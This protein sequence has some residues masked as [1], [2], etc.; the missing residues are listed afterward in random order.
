MKISKTGFTN[1]IRC[2]RYGAL[3][4]IYRKKGQALVTFSEDMD[5]LMT[6]ENKSKTETLLSDMYDENDDDLIQKEDI[7]LN[8]MMPYY[9]EIEGLTAKAVKKLFEGEFTFNMLDTYKQKKFEMEKEGYYFYCFLDG[10]LEQENGFKIFETKST[11]SRKYMDMMHNKESMFA[12]SPEGIL[13]L[14]KDLGFSV[15]E[16]YEKK[17][18]KLLDRYSDVGRY[19]Y[20]LAFQRYVIE[21]SD[22]KPIGS[23]KYY[24]A[25]LNKDYVFDG[26]TDENSKPIYDES[27]IVFIDFTSITERYRPIIESD[28]NLVINNLNNMNAAPVDIGKHCQRK[29]RKQCQFFDICWKHVPTQNSILTYLGN[30]HGFTDSNGEKRDR[31]DLINEGIVEALQIPEDWLKRENNVIQRQVIESDEPYYNYRKIR[32]GILELRYP[33]Y[34]LDFESFPCPLPRYKGESPYM[35]SLFQYSIHIEHTPGVC[36]KELDN[37]AFLARNHDDPREALIEGMIDI[38][39]QDGGSV[40]VYNI[41]FEKTRINE[42]A[43]LFPVYKDALLDIADRLFDLMD[44]VKGNTKLYKDLGYDEAEAKKINYYHTDLNGSYSI[45]KVLPLFSNLT[46]KGLPIGNGSEALVTYAQ[47]PLMDPKTFERTYKDL[48]NYCKQDTWAMVEILNE[49]RKIADVR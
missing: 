46:Y 2:N 5:D 44:I 47:F 19:V 6:S 16:K 9:N 12:F 41:A 32:E 34:H 25:V 33:I 1:I 4:E 30:H 39:K 49:L 21:H 27:I 29:D 36:D 18:D 38:I 3:E 40:L 31:Y 24:L 37:Y 23:Q 26:R 28:M 17:L 7:Q 11:T 22:E 10:F 45:K 42:L 20:D 48:V 8:A 43:R 13:M 14:T 15:D 35:Q